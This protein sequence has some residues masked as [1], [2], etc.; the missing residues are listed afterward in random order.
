M[1]DDTMI[2]TGF[3]AESTIWDVTEGVDLSGR[4]A[5]VTGA[6][7]GIGIETARALAATGAEVMLAVRDTPPSSGPLS[8]SAARPATRPSGS[9]DSTSPTST[10]CTRSSP[11]GT[12]RC[13]CS[14]TTPE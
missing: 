4:R 6:S 13:I 14:S 3:G 1:T 12:G 9:A 5:I 10:P 7:S 2:H 11:P 8:I